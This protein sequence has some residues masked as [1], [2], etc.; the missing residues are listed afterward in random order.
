MFFGQMTARQEG[1]YRIDLPVPDATD[2]Q[3]TRRLQVQVPDRER[4]HPQ[5]ND[6]LL[7][8]I[9]VRTGG[10]YYVGLEATEGHSGLPPL[11]AQ[12]SDR[13]EV[14]RLTGAPDR[15]FEQRLMQWLLVGIAAA[16]CLEWLTRRL[17]RL[18]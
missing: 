13:T 5:R 15:T 3:L 6:A 17:C 4:Q 18:A 11:A 10:R 8:D 12:L 2:Q 7:S 1:S 16:L 14:T 9:A